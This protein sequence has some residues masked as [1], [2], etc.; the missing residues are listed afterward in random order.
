MKRLFA[1]LLGIALLGACLAGGAESA[2]G[3]APCAHAAGSAA[4]PAYRPQLPYTKVYEP[5]T[6]WSM[7]ATVAWRADADALAVAAADVRPATGFVWLD[8]G[9]NVYDRDGGLLSA[10]LQR[11]IEATTAGIIPAFYI[12][13]AETAAALK[14]FLPGSGLLDCFVV[15]TPENSQFVKAVADLPH[16]RGMLDYTSFEAPDRDALLDMVATTNGAHGKVILMSAAAATWENVRQLQ[17]LGS[18]VWARTPAD[19]RTLLTMYTNG[20]NGVV[21]DDYAAAIRAVE[22]FSDDAP[23][24]LRIPFITG[25]RGDPS[26]FVE[27]TL[28]SARGAFEAGVDFVEN[29]IQLSADGELFILHDDTPYRLLGIDGVD[30]AEALTLGELRAHSFMWDDAHVG[31]IDHNEVPAAESRG[32]ALYGQAEGKAYT[33]PTL[34]EYIE[35]YKGTGLAH[36]TEI[37]SHDPAIIPVY[38]A[39]VD[40][41]DAWD[42]FYTITFNSEILDA[43][44]ADYPEIAVGALSVAGEE[45]D[46]RITG[47]LGAIGSLFTDTDAEESLQQL[48]GTLDKWNATYNPSCYLYSEAAARAGRHRGLT[49]WPWTYTASTRWLFARDYLAGMEGL[50]TDWPWIASDYIVRIKAEDAI[51]SDADS[52]PQPMCVTQAGE[53]RTLYGAEPVLLEKLSATQTLM[54]WRYRATLD[55]DG[56]ALGQYW[57]YSNP[58]IFTAE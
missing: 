18:T 19:T 57:L 16:V 41:Y 11:Y 37:K 45:S 12:S 40:E 23:T 54:I 10:D 13:D 24:L 21:V 22:L 9:L 35:A 44:Y 55:W 32:G 1:L 34:R 48:Y 17:K 3:G 15:S 47:I 5:A 53:E 39:L 33:V 27:N 28:D 52:I 26:Q 29:D 50:T 58:F 7:A 56:E 43:L 36:A 38:K 46:N 31:I 6:S 49:S 14:A 2:R 4:T 51:A 20:V 8:A 25:H 42:Q 30:S